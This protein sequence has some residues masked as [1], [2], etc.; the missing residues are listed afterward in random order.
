[1]E[2][3]GGLLLHSYYTHP[4]IS[5]ESQVESQVE[6]LLWN[7]RCGIITVESHPDPLLGPSRK[8]QRLN[9]RYL[10]VI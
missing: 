1:M 6:S 8:P 9:N 10:I 4:W 5:V 7:H 2:T 3:N